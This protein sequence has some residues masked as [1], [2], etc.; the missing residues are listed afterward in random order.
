MRRIFIFILLFFI[1]ILSYA[2]SSD[3]LENIEYKQNIA[4]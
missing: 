1:P 3:L 2:E 4:I